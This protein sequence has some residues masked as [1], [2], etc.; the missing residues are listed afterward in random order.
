VAKKVSV[1][2]SASMTDRQLV[3]L[4]LVAVSLAYILLTGLQ[5]SA[6]A[7]QLRWVRCVDRLADGSIY[8]GQP[9]C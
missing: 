5:P 7:Y 3:W 2:F 1:P 4:Y 9:E 6:Q 8:G